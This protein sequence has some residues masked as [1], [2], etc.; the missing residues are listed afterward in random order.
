MSTKQLFYFECFMFHCFSV[1]F[2]QH[3]LNLC[4]ENKLI[5]GFM[6]WLSVWCL[7]TSGGRSELSL[8]NFLLWCVDLQS[9][10]QIMLHNKLQGK[11][12]DYPARI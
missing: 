4:N 6:S 10:V 12:I 7:E 1:G 9:E 2:H 8:K 11:H 5:K 3:S